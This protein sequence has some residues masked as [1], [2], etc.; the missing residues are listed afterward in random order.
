[1]LQLL[2]GHCA[3]AGSTSLSSGC[4][5]DGQNA[6]VCAAQHGHREAVDMFPLNRFRAPSF[7]SCFDIELCSGSRRQRLLPRRSFKPDLIQKVWE[8]NPGAL[9]VAN[10][11]GS[12][13]STMWLTPLMNGPSNTSNGNFRSSNSRPLSRNWIRLI[14]KQHYQERLLRGGVA[15]R[16]CGQ[17][18]SLFLP[19]DCASIIC[20]YLLK[21]NKN[22]E[23]DNTE[24]E[25]NH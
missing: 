13:P 4:G 2:E 23:H 5:L 6:S 22:V 3:A 9:F 8:M 25:Q 15:E 18:L 24:N 16:E 19:R 7:L 17:Q 21:A 14:V 20:A 12:T 1:M 11:Y 10:Q